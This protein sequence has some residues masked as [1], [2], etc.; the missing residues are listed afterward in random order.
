MQEYLRSGLS[1]SCCLAVLACTSSPDSS[2]NTDP[3]VADVV[4]VGRIKNDSITQASGLARSHYR[5]EMLWTMNDFGPPVL[6]AIGTDG[7]DYGSVAIRGAE[8]TDWEDLAA[9]ELDGKSYLLIGD[10]GDNESDRAYRTIYIVEEPQLSQGQHIEVEPAWLIRFTYPD[11][12]LDC[13]SVA[14]D[15]EDE[16]ILLLSKRE[17]PARLF[18]LPLHP[19]ADDVVTVRTI[20]SLGVLPQPDERDIDRAPIDDVWYWQPVAMDLSADGRMAAILTYGGVYLFDRRAGKSWR[21]TFGRQS[22]FVDLAGFAEAEALALSIDG[23]MIFVTLEGGGAPILR[24][25]HE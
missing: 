10:V 9:F 12:P 8:N 16:R 22:R 17:I 23:K 18:E 3:G 25:N 15:V 19:D 14:V 2:D 20:M 4:V 1:I 5:D 6:Y 7:S 13:E 11:G 21:D 24:I